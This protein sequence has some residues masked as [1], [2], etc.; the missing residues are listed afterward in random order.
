MLHSVVSF[1]TV[2]TFIAMSTFVPEPAVDEDKATLSGVVVDADTDAP[3]AN[4]TVFLLGSDKSA[5][6]GSDGTFDFGEVRTGEHQIQVL[7]EGYPE[8]TEIVEILS[9]ENEITI[10]LESGY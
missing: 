3:I 6:T 4:A 10:E 8:A 9:G 5:E 7:A 1:I 2:M